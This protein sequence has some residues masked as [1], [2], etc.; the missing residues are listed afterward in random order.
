MYIF[1][2][3]VSLF[4]VL[5]PQNGI[6]G[7]T[8]AT[9]SL[10]FLLFVVDSTTGGKRRTF[11]R[12]S[13]SIFNSRARRA[14][15]SGVSTCRVTIR[16]DLTRTLSSQRVRCRG[17]AFSVGGATSSVVRV[18]GI[19]L[20]IPCGSPSSSR[21]VSTMAS[22]ANFSQRVVEVVESRR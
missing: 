6:G 13:F 3:V 12:S 22:C 18:D 20:S 1:S 17:V 19:Y 7:A 11:S 15:T 21:V 8:N 2:M 16:G 14:T 5:L 9:L 10:V 4:H